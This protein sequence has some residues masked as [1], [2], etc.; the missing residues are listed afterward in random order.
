MQHTAVWLTLQSLH[1]IQLGEKLV[2]HTIS[3]SCA[4]V[5][6]PGGQWVKLIKE[7]DARLGSLRPGANREKE[8]IPSPQIVVS[9][10]YNYY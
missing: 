10:A 1:P 3:D 8:I 9:G 7:Q 5:A 4:V 6:P 2:D